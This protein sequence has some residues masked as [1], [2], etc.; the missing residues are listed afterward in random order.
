MTQMNNP[1]SAEP[2]PA[3]TPR[4]VLVIYNPTAGR[5][6]RKKLAD[7]VTALRERGC[8]V[9]ERQTSRRGDAEEFARLTS[10]ADVDVI[11]AAGGDG[12]VNEVVNGMVAAMTAGRT[13]IPCL[14]VIPLGTANVLALEIGLAPKDN[15]HIADTIAAGPTRRVHLGIANG[16]H[17]VLMA[18]AGLDAHV[19][20]GVN[21]ALKRA[22]GKLAYV[23]E[24]VKQA[25]GYDFPALQVRANGETYEASMA[26]AC[27]GRYYGGPF[28]AAPEAGLHKPKLEVCILP[29]SGV[30]GVVRYG[31]ALPMNKLSEL[32]EVKVV[33]ADSITILGPRGAPL[34]G[35]GDIVARLPA[36]ISISPRTVDLIVPAQ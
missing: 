5:R 13:D 33:S 19:V 36:E 8:E 26:V 6:R 18:G 25:F 1:V 15:Q 9:A 3:V 29:K 11:A 28:I 27:K 10:S 2:S 22:T 23:V 24:S 30:G 17:F 4:R 35:D 20:E 31:L 21:V 12:T 34:Q 14:A 16:R 32:P 7:V